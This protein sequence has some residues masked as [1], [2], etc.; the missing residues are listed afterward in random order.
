MRQVRDKYRILFGKTER[1][2][3]FG[4]PR[5]RWVDDDIMDLKDVGCE[6]VDWIHLPEIR[7]QWRD[8]VNTVINHW[9]L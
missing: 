6:D 1:K 4:R 2:R 5:H 9:V 3:P 7:S 8:L